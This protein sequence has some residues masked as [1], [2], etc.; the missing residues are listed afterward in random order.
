[1]EQISRKSGRLAKGAV[2]D[3]EKA[4][5]YMINMWRSGLLGTFIMDDVGPVTLERKKEYLERLGGSIN[6]AKKTSKGIKK[7]ARESTVS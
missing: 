7:A 1:L 5:R 3:I 2:P 6:Q 4:A